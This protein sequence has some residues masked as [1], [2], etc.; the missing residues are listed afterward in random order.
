[1][2]ANLFKKTPDNYKR[3]SG[4]KTDY[5]TLAHKKKTIRVYK[6]KSRKVGEM[7]AKHTKNASKLSKKTRMKYSVYLNKNQSSVA[8]DKE[9]LK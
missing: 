1:M 3:L 4:P 2:A 6:G 8:H 9:A 7:T 5:K